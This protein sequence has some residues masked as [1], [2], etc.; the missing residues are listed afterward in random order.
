MLA[1]SHAAIQHIFSSFSHSGFIFLFK[2][3]RTKHTIRHLQFQL[4]A[5]CIIIFGLRI[6]D[7][8]QQ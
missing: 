5:G 7:P 8:E 3:H 6:T 4:L 1:R 2:N